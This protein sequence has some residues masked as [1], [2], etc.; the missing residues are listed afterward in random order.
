M[1]RPAVVGD[2]IFNKHPGEISLSV[3]ADR[4][5]RP[6]EY[7]NDDGF[8]IQICG[9]A[10]HP[11][12]IWITWIDYNEKTDPTAG[13]IDCAYYLRVKADDKQILEWNVETYNPFF[14]AIT[15]YVDWHGDQIVYV[16]LEKHR[17]YGVTLTLAGDIYKVEL[18]RVGSEFRIDDDVLS[19]MQV[20]NYQGLIKQFRI[21]SW[22]ELPSLTEDVARKQGIIEEIEGE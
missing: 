6:I 15:C 9:G 10:I 12:K 3:I 1:R 16:Y 4:L 14:G 13:W 21:P 7:T 5:K 8:K 17:L 19:L 22:Q 20:E 18:G 2:F 11:N